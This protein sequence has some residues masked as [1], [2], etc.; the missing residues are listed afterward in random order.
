MLQM[1]NKLLDALIVEVHRGRVLGM[2]FMHGD[3]FCDACRQLFLT[4]FRELCE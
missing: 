3:P 2:S 1:V 4:G